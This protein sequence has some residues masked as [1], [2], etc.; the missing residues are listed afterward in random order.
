[1]KSCWTFSPLSLIGAVAKEERC[2]VKIHHVAFIPPDR[3]LHCVINCPVCSPWTGDCILSADTRTCHQ[4][5]GHVVHNMQAGRNGPGACLVGITTLKVGTI[6]LQT[7]DL[8]PLTTRHAATV[9]CIT[10]ETT[11]TLSWNSHSTHSYFGQSSKC[12]KIPK[13]R[14]GCARF[15]P[16]SAPRNCRWTTPTCLMT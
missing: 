1:M 9:K 6:N 4:Y 7:S 12:H 2:R 15:L 10:E 16:T 11:T 13:R 3:T 8:G 5:L 14:R